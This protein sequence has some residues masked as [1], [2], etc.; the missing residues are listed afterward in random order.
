M[1]SYIFTLM[2]SGFF[3]VC[4]HQAVAPVLMSFLCIVRPIVALRVV[5]A[6]GLA[7]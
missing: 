1:L 2:V 7:V 4:V 6:D 5:L 3:T